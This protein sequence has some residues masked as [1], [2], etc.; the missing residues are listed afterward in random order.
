MPELPEVESLVRGA[1][2]DLIG[3][4]FVSVDFHRPDIREPIPIEQVKEILV[5]QTVEAVTRRG[6]YMLVHTHLGIVGIHLGMSGRF[7]SCEANAPLVKHTHAVFTLPQ[8]MQY[9]FVDPRRFGR[10]FALNSHELATHPFFADLGVEPLDHGLPLGQHLF[11]LSRRKSQSVK[12]FLMDGSIVVGV[13]NI[14]ASESLWRAKIHPE[15]KASRVT[16]QQYEVLS[17]QIVDVLTEAIKAGGTSFRDYRDK[18]GN[19]GYFQQNLAV[20]GRESKP[21]ARCEALIRRVVQGGRSTFFCPVCQSAKNAARGN[22]IRQ[23]PSH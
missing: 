4:R 22:K 13:G 7:T 6:K 15:Q 10:I 5:D 12:Q 17:R 1:R 8:G 19:P 9:R 2:G 21:C 23:T 14:Y 16:R 3:R 18:D 11:T 20:Y